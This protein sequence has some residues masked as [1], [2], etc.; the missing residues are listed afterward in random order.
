MVVDGRYKIGRCAILHEW[1]TRCVAQSHLRIISVTSKAKFSPMALLYALALPS[2]QREIR[3]L[4][5]I[6]STL[7][8]LG[9]R[10]KEI[11]IPDPRSS[12]KWGDTLSRFDEAVTERARRSAYLQGFDN[13]VEL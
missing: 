12:A 3:R 10:I 13:E 8:G 1:S 5:F 2:V 4:V 11:R 7:G 6:Q 9:S